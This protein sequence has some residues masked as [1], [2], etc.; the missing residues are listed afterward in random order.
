MCSVAVPAV[1]DDAELEDDVD[2]SDLVSQTNSSVDLPTHTTLTTEPNIPL[3]VP[4]ESIRDKDESAIA[5]SL[6]VTS[7]NNYSNVE[8][9][10]FTEEKSEKSALSHSSSVETL[11]SI[12]SLSPKRQ[13]LLKKE[14]DQDLNGNPSVFDG[15]EMQDSPLPSPLP[16]GIGEERGWDVGS[17]LGDEMP[18]LY[19]VRLLCRRFLLQ[20]EPGVLIPD[21]VTRVSL[22]SLALGCIASSFTLCPHIFFYKLFPQESAGKSIAHVEIALCLTNVAL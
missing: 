6:V 10:E 9:G 3:P 11:L 14:S 22:K 4:E 13:P 2:S 16:P 7:E 15:S 1:S 17:I 12:R 8:I 5:S 18:L 19:C 21:K 20:G